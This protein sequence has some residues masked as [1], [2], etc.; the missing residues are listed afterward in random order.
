MD[1]GRA[2][3]MDAL[4][5]TT[6]PTR[7]RCKSAI[8]QFS[9]YKTLNDK[10]LDLVGRGR[11]AEATSALRETTGCDLQTAKAWVAR[12]GLECFAN[13]PYPRCG[14]RYE[15]RKQNNVVS[16][17]MTGLKCCEIAV[18]RTTGFWIYVTP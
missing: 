15:L 6:W 3:A 12:N 18:S 7:T 1:A 4:F 8:P 2:A 17:G 14:I 13:P 10:L 11:K 9:F 16:A 5:A